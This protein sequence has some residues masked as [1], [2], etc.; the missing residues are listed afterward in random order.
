[1]ADSPLRQHGMDIQ[2]ARL[3]QQT[4]Q[5]RDMIRRIRAAQIVRETLERQQLEAQDPSPIAPRLA[6]TPPSQA[7]PL[8]PVAAPDAQVPSPASPLLQTLSGAPPVAPGINEPWPSAGEQFGYKRPES[9][10]GKLALQEYQKLRAAH[11]RSRP[12]RDYGEAFGPPISDD[13]NYFKDEGVTVPEG[14]GPAE[15]SIYVQR[16]LARRRAL[17]SGRR[18]EERRGDI[19]GATLLGGSAAGRREAAEHYARTWGPGST[20][21]DMLKMGTGETQDELM[22]DASIAAVGKEFDP[23][24]PNPP[25]VS[26]LGQTLQALQNRVSRRG[27][28]ARGQALDDPNLD[29]LLAQP[30]NSQEEADRLFGAS[31]FGMAA[32]L[33]LQ[34]LKTP[35]E[36]IDRI[37]SYQHAVDNLQ[38]LTRK[39]SR[40]ALGATLQGSQMLSGMI[41]SLA[42]TGEREPRFMQNPTR[43]IQNLRA[44]V[45][46][47]PD[48]VKSQRLLKLIDDVRSGELS[49]SQLINARHEIDRLRRR[50][51]AKQTFDMSPLWGDM[52]KEL[53][54]GY[55]RS[56]QNR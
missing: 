49:R 28:V 14:L 17:G 46:S 42:L 22:R 4:D 20:T 2:A 15:D 50:R 30:R 19:R 8:L 36:R 5:E 9:D 35:R 11:E 7:N 27:P 29:E 53:S 25:N 55:P 13:P 10:E 16:E 44:N 39:E 37:A 51:L 23:R 47:N 38:A 33:D 18:V 26:A 6:G 56:D 34:G 40:Q 43:T 31:Q 52:A 12:M 48:D 1:M 54:P 45:A 21:L 41:D 24:N 32:N 3:R